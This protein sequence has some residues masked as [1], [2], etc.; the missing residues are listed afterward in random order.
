MHCNICAIFNQIEV[1]KEL[2][3]RGI[4]LNEKTKLKKTSFQLAISRKNFDFAKFL[5]DQLIM[6]KLENNNNNNIN[7]K[8]NNERI[9]LNNSNNLNNN[10]EGNNK[11]NNNNNEEIN[12]QF[13]LDDFFNP[14]IK[15]SEKKLIK[16]IEEIENE[17]ENYFNFFIYFIEKTNLNLL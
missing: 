17:R 14:Y 13:R 3:K 16:K 4:K 7:N 1:A 11:N 5:L 8:N 9:N 15:T 12:I 10:N 2:I 6:K